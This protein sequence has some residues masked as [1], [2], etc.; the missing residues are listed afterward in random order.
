MRSV[1]ESSGKPSSIHDFRTHQYRVFMAEPY[2]KLDLEDEIAW[3]EE[4]LGKLR[5]MARNPDLFHSSRT[6]H[7]PEE[8]HHRHFKEHVLD[9]IPFH[10]KI[11]SDHRK[12]LKTALDIMPEKRYRKLC[13][14]SKKVDAVPDY[15]VFDRIS[16]DFFFV[17]DRPTPGKVKWSRIVKRK[18]LGEVMFLE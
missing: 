3:H 18:G 2:L 11:L 9:S 6:S 4:H 8:H 10:E 16:R 7:K 17:V 12:R 5:L 13:R 14:V 15:I 1:A